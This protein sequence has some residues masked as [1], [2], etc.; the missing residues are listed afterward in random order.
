[1]EG[2]TLMWFFRGF[3]C[4]FEE[5]CFYHSHK[6]RIIVILILGLANGTA[7]SISEGDR[8]PALQLDSIDS[9]MIGL[10]I[11]SD[12]GKINMNILLILNVKWKS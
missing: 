10:R 8:K 1:M 9:W 2:Q 3:V 11:Q 7:L 4:L 6:E 12:S 5:I